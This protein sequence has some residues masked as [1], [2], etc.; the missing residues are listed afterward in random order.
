MIFEAFSG[1]KVWI[2]EKTALVASYESMEREQPSK[3]KQREERE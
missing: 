2:L 1:S 3:E